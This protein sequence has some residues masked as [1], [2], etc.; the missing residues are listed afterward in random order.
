MLVVRKRRICKES[1]LS[2]QERGESERVQSRQQA[3]RRLTIGKMLI[4]SRDAR[5][6]GGT[7]ERVL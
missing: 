1:I 4:R 6:E 5:D 3:N 2:S 7:K